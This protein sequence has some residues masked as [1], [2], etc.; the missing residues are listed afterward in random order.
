MLSKKQ[1]GLV[2]LGILLS[3]G[4]YAQPFNFPLNIPSGKQGQFHVQGVAIDK[5]NGFVYFSFTDKLVKTDR[6]GNLIGSVTGLTGHL[7]DIDLKVDEN[8]IYG[9]LEYKNDAIGKNI[10]NKLGV[11]EKKDQVGFYV[12]IFDAARIVRPNMDAQKEDLLQTVCIREAVKD[13]KD[14]V[15]VDGKKL[16]HRYACSGIDGL[17]FGPAFGAIK[18]SKQYLYVAYGIYGDTTRTDNDHQVI[19]RYDVKDWGR[20][21]RPLSQDDLH[22]AGPAKPLDKYFI[23]TGATNY[24]IQNLAYDASTGNFFAAVYKGKKSR[25]PN[26]DLFMIDGRQKPVK[27]TLIPD[28]E[29]VKMLALSAAGLKDPATGI[30]GWR[31]EWGSTRLCP[32]GDGKFYISHNSKDKDGQQQTVL[33][34]YQWVGS[35][36]EAFM[37]Y[38]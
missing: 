38:R 3:F 34:L 8:K 14:S 11:A 16:A 5:V 24:G 26:Y 30:R 15:I 7:G 2:L 6:Q 20:Y 1:L 9:S 10:S 4:V 33:H 35:E 12:A 23:R 25:Y 32:M 31:F 13:H 21:A 22:T 17:T 19:L 18:D 37:M 36:E 28:G 29:Q 27:R